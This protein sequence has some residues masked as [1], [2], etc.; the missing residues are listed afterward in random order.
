MV[1]LGPYLHHALDVTWWLFYFLLFAGHNLLHHLH[2]GFLLFHYALANFW[3]FFLLLRLGLNILLNVIEKPVDIEHLIFVI[4]P[5]L[6]RVDHHPAQW[7][8]HQPTDGSSS[9]L[10]ACPGV[11]GIPSL[12]LLFEYLPFDLGIDDLGQLGH[13]LLEDVGLLELLVQDGARLF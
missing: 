6:Q 3:L 12:F 5:G 2:F 13:S 7:V 1:F 4:V 8:P 11:I 10:V 9:H